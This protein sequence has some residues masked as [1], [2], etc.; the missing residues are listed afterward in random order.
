MGRKC[1]VEGC[2]SGYDSENK[3]KKT[4]SN[5]VMHGFPADYDDCQ[6]WIKAL[7]RHKPVTKFIGVCSL[8]W[9]AD[10]KLKRVGRHTYPSLPPSIFPPKTTSTSH[11]P[12]TQLQTVTPN[13][14]QHLTERKSFNNSP[15]SPSTNNDIA[16][17]NQLEELPQQ[18][19]FVTK[20]TELSQSQGVAQPTELPQ[21]QCVNKQ[22][23]LLQRLIVRWTSSERGK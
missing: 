3:N 1:C 5:V 22:T 8:H 2:K 15:Q 18:S 17:S 13:T 10:V 9:P 7:E 19:Q 23:E 4:P 21:S 6:S 16:M 12:A 11:L 20:H 14:T